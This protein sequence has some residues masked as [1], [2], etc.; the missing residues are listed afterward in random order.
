[1]LIKIVPQ[2]TPPAAARPSQRSV[3]SHGALRRCRM[4][5]DP[6]E[7]TRCGGQ[8]HLVGLT[9]GPPLIVTS[10]RQCLCAPSASLL[11]RARLVY[12]GPSGLFCQT[13]QHHAA[14]RHTASS[15]PSRQVGTGL[16]LTCC[17]VVASCGPKSRPHSVKGL[18]A[19]WIIVIMNIFNVFLLFLAHFF[20]VSF[21]A[22]ISAHCSDTETLNKWILICKNQSTNKACVSISAS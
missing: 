9:C 7:W 3:S 21:I 18:R 11:P 19:Y 4:L 6:V 17:K 1:M 5:C 12:R 13:S 16:L 10:G 2:I 15:L 22:L 20:N 14:P 8:D